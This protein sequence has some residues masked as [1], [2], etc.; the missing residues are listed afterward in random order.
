MLMA[1]PVMDPDQPGLQVSEDEVD[2]GQEGFGFIRIAA[3]RDGMVG[4]NPVCE[5]WRR[6]S[7]RR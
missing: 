3:L 6:R 4:R 7:S 5:G 2:D 1:H